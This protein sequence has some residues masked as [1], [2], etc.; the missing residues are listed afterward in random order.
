[1]AELGPNPSRSE[2]GT[3]DSETP[4][5]EQN[6]AKSYYGF[7]VYLATYLIFGGIY[8]NLMAGG[9]LTVTCRAIARQCS[10]S[11]GPTFRSRCCGVL[12]SPI[13]PTST[14]LR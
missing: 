1:M 7:A 4:A 13:T 10:T 5:T 3:P 6:G 12:G 9:L 2:A 14:E 8:L 11:S